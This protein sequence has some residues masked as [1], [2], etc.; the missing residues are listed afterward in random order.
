VLITPLHLGLVLHLIP[1]PIKHDGIMW[2]LESDAPQSTEFA[3]SRFCVPHIQRRGW[4]LF[5]DS[6]ILCLTDIA[7]LFAL[8]DEKYAVMV[9]KHQHDSGD[10]IKMDGQVQTFYKRKNWSSVILWNCSHPAHYRL[11][12]MRLNMWPGRDLH[13]FKWLQDDEIGELPP[14]WNHLVDVQ[15]PIDAKILHYTL[16]TPNLAGY[17]NC[18][19][20]D[21]WLEEQCQ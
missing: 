3:R 5:A 16:G 14:E 10:E 11:T 4:A 9:V 7:E 17:E 15:E 19:F 8:A 1:A 6:D 13:A 18:G 12:K 20:N 21:L 2:D